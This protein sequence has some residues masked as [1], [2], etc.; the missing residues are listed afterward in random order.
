MH[1]INHF[2]PVLHCV[3]RGKD[4]VDV[5]ELG[6]GCSKQKGGKGD[7]RRIVCQ[8]ER[9]VPLRFYRHAQ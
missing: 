2:L 3:F 7:G 5:I 8:G 1:E 9:R 4:F 6:R